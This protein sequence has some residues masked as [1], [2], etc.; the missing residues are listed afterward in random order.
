MEKNFAAV[1]LAAGYSSR[2]G[3][4]K[5]LLP[6]AGKTAVQHVIDR[7]S[8]AGVRHIYVVTGH[9]GNEL[10]AVLST[11]GVTTVYNPAFHLGMFSSVQAGCRALPAEIDAFFLVPVDTPLFETNTVHLLRER[12]L[13]GK[14]CI[15][16]PSY[17]RRRGHPTLIASTL[18]P[19]ILAGSHE[20]GLRGVL[21]SCGEYCYVNVED[22]GVLLD[23]DVLVD[24]EQLKEY[25]RQSVL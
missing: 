21:E 7:F 10:A 16:F 8:D 25:Y 15:V 20:D 22:K 4:F 23:M 6:I 2:M 14:E 17:A 12:Y 24:Y 5:P 1:I 18:I 3:E 9:R 19:N 13:Q 11:C